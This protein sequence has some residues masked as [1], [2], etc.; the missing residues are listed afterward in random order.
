MSGFRS[1]ARDAASF[2]RG[3]CG[4][5]P[6]ENRSFGAD[7]WSK[8]KRYEGI[9]SEGKSFIF[10]DL[11]RLAHFICTKTLDFS[12]RYEPSLH[13]NSVAPRQLHTPSKR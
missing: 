10:N 8:L 3:G 9:F 6:T 13:Q 12:A 7:F 1:G 5:H 11:Q 2:E 4:V